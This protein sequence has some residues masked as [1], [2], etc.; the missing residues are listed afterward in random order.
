M[1]TAALYGIHSYPT[2]L[3]LDPEGHLVKFGDE[4]MLADKLDEKKP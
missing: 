2:I 4:V 3:L 1:K